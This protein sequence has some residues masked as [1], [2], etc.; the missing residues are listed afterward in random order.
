MNKK[1]VKKGEKNNR[2]SAEWIE[3]EWN[4]NELNK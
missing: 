3:I 1:E 2:I 4:S